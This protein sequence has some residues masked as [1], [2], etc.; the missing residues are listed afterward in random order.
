MAKVLKGPSLLAKGSDRNQLFIHCSYMEL[1]IVHGSDSN[2]LFSHG[3]D[4]KLTHQPWFLYDP[5]H[6][7]RGSVRNQLTDHGFHIEINSVATALVVRDLVTRQWNK[8]THPPTTVQ[9]ETTLT[10][11]LNGFRGHLSCKTISSRDTALWI[12]RKPAQSFIHK[13]DDVTV[14]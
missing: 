2:Q 7:P 6:W 4:R 5:L 3:S 10:K 8:T 12:L 14:G 1:S 9:Q 11:V 13:I